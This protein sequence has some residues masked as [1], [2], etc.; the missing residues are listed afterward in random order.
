MQPGVLQP[1][2][3][4]SLSEFKVQDRSTLLFHTYY[5]IFVRAQT[6]HYIDESQDYQEEKVYGKGQ[7]Y[8]KCTE[9]SADR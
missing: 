6:N 7:N 8:F 2:T 9:E 3:S 4:Y 5:I 1:P